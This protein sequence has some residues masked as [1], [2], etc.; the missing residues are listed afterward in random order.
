M[1]VVVVTTALLLWSEARG[2][3]LFP[4]VPKLRGNGMDDLVV[5]L[6]PRG[7]LL[8]FALCCSFT[9]AS[10]SELPCPASGIMGGIPSGFQQFFGDSMPPNCQTANKLVN[11]WSGGLCNCLS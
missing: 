8:A 5:V 6:V 11:L 7:E 1:G 10:S 9:I 4:D 3:P 2:N